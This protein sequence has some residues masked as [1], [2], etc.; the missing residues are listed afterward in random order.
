M[1]QA[2]AEAVQP[3]HGICHICHNTE[4]N[5]SLQI[6][7]TDL[8]SVLVGMQ[9]GAGKR[10]PPP[11]HPQVFIQRMM[12]P[13]EFY[14]VLCRGLLFRWN[15][16]HQNRYNTPQGAPWG[17]DPPKGPTRGGGVT[18]GAVTVTVGA[19]TVIFYNEVI[20]VSF[21]FLIPKLILLFSL[22]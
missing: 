18:V 6:P 22:Q 5:Y 15:S 13:H 20:D 19:V 1:F 17:K 3:M 21:L 14:M 8:E 11:L 2:V 10:Y 16:K 7:G 4:A 9:E 12:G